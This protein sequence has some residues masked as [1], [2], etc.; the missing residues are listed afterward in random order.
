LFL[1]V[2]ARTVGHGFSRANKPSESLWLQPLRPQR[3]KSAPLRS[4]TSTSPRLPAI[5]LNTLGQKVTGGRAPRIKPHFPAR[6]K[7]K[8]HP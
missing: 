1:S 2:P 5:S 8:T 3:F 4:H 6:G 7:I